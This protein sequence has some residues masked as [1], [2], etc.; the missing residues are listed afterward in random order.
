MD[1]R[2]DGKGKAEGGTWGQGALSC[3]VPQSLGDIGAH[4][5]TQAW[6]VPCLQGGQDDAVV[7][8]RLVTAQFGV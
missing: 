5:Q 3:Q 2:Q 6:L 8:R 1:G 4:G 7:L